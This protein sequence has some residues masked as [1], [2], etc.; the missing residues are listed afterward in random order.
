MQSCTDSAV[1]AHEL[2]KHAVN[3]DVHNNCGCQVVRTLFKR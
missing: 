2:S 1:S 3:P